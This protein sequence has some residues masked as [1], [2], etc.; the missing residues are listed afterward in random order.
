[1][2]GTEMRSIAKIKISGFWIYSQRASHW[3]RVNGPD[4][5]IQNVSRK[6]V[7]KGYAGGAQQGGIDA[8]N[9]VLRVFAD[10]SGPKSE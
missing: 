5:Q 8:G 1:M 9:E 10:S 6:L 2:C 4:R 3:P 7:E